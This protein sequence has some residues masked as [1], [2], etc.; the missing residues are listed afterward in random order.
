V[1][2]TRDELIG[3]GQLE[4]TP[5]A[6]WQDAWGA[7]RGNIVRAIVEYVTNADDS[8]KR[9]GRKGRVLVEVEH[10]RSN[11]PWHV[12]IRDR[13]EGMTFREMKERIGRQGVRAS[14]FEG[15]QAVRGNLGLGSKD[16]A[17]FGRVIFQS[18]KDGIYAAFAINDQGDISGSPRPTKVTKEIREDLGIPQNGTVVMIEVRKPVACPRHETL[19]QNLQNQILLRDIL[20]DPD[21]EVFLL[22]AGKPGARRERLTWVAPKTSARAQ[23]KQVELPGYKGAK[24]DIFIAESEQPF[25]DE[26]RNSL[27]RRSGLLI[28]GRRAIYECTLFSFDGNPYAQAFT[29]FVKCDDID[30]IAADYDD[31]EEKRLAHPADNPM[32]IIN[33][34]RDGLTEGHPLYQ[35]IRRL[36]EATLEPLVTERERRARERLV[37]VEHQS[38]TRL[39]SQLCREAARFMQEAAEEEEVE[40]Q[41]SRNGREPAPALI[42]I[43]PAVE[44]PPSTQ[45]TLTVL[46]SRGG[47]EESSPEVKLSF[48]PPEIVDSDSLSLRLRPSRRRDDVLSGTVK[49]AAGPTVG[50]T[51]L[52]ARLGARRADCA[53]EVIEPASP[54]EPEP[55][56]GFEFERD[57]YRLILGKPKA[58]KLRAPLNTYPNG[59]VIWVTSS[60]SH[61]VVLDGG[62]TA[63]RPQPESL[64]MEGTI[65][66][67]GRVDNQQARITASDPADNKAVVDVE[68]IRREE[69]GFEI[70]LVPDVQGDQRAQWSPDRS[71]LRIMGEHPSVKVYLGDK[72]ENYPG[73]ATA[74]FKALLAELVSDAVVRR[75]LLEKYKDDEL[76]AGTLYVQHYRL[77]GR[78]LAKAHRIVASGFSTPSRLRK[79]EE[80]STG[81]DIVE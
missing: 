59:T 12:R 33:R 29:G 8:Y 38:T 66:I 32:P 71:E 51:L 58:L 61:I 76:D 17:C 39:L 79:N 75:I 77:M 34:Q 54:P 23:L 35:A 36:A 80:F 14:G 7:M 25:P 65:R 15:G 22:H 18:I 2:V 68:V 37:Q 28:K 43:P 57:S 9:L 50:A 10:R 67:E 63:L 60:N 26:G 48:A 27:V 4:R 6:F 31:R 30:R 11:E 69:A 47:L 49:I 44:M 73:Q 46:A 74:Q 13:A 55:P 56:A 72:L 20:Q 40:L 64:A 45:R 3:L 53:V 21:R 24:A 52:E 16:P 62:R 42:I 5:R 70:K 81:S 78:F 41:F 19:K 1:V